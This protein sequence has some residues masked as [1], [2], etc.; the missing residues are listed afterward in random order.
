MEPYN[1]AMAILF[2]EI[3]NWQMLAGLYSIENGIRAYVHCFL[4]QLVCMLIREIATV[5]RSSLILS[6]VQLCIDVVWTPRN[7]YDCVFCQ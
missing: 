1:V 6:H 4:G 5:K 3:C 2:H 7:V